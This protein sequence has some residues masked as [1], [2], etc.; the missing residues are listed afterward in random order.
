MWIMALAAVVFAAAPSAWAQKAQQKNVEEMGA[1]R[2]QIET[3]K[4]Q[5]DPVLNSL[6]AIVAAGNAD[7]A[8]AY[9]TFQKELSKMDSQVEQARKTK[10]DMQKKGEAL[11]QEWEKK[12]GAIT[13]PEIKAAADANR[14]KL[15]ELYKSIEPD[16]AAAK[17][18][19]NAFV[20]DL[21]DLNAYFQVDLSSAGI[22]SMSGTV[23]KCNT[24]GKN[25]QGLL[26]KILATLDQVKAQMAPGGTGA[27]K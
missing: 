14:A 25:V 26:D 12:M 5:I 8:A 13:N 20:T 22:A 24:E 2:A 10:A 19:G 18:A 3:V 11:F 21:K 23:T 7:P 15:Q 1:F 4:N 17:D 6:N 9:K 16:V 27:A